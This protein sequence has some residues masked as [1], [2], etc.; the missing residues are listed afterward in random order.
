MLKGLDSFKNG[1]YEQALIDIY[2]K[3]DATLQS[4]P[5][6]KKKLATYKKAADPGAAMFARGGGDDIAMGTGCTAVSAIVTPTKIYVGNSGDSRIV[7]GVKNGSGIKAV[8][9]SEDHKPDNPGEKARIERAGG[10]V[11]ENR[12]KGVLNL[13]RSLGDLE[14]KQDPKKPPADQMITCVPEMMNHDINNETSFMLLACDGI[15]DCLTNQQAIDLMH[16]RLQVKK[17]TEKLSGIV[18]DMFDRIIAPSVAAS[19]G[20]GCDNMTAI[21]VQFHHT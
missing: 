10:F 9:L 19:G 16:E 3:I 8:P 17:P 21:L 20:L 13:S 11:E 7:V 14:Y 1:Q 12:V 2:V 5:A 18:A 4:D 6:T 15:W